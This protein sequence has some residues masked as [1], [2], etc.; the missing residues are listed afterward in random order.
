MVD[1]EEGNSER[2][3][4]WGGGGRGVFKE[5]FQ[6]HLKIGREQR[7]KLFVG[8]GVLKV[9]PPLPPTPPPENFNLTLESCISIFFQ[10]FFKK[11]RK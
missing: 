11:Q 8:E 3:L 7:Q 9:S 5:S 4:K 2:C 10:K 1:G 6:I